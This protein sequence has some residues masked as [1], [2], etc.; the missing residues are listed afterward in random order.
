MEQVKSTLKAKWLKNILR[1]VGI[2]IL[3]VLITLF[4]GYVAITFF[5]NINIQQWFQHT[6]LFWLGVRCMLYAIISGLVCGIY[7]H[8]AIS[9]KTIGFLVL[10]I[11]CCEILNILYIIN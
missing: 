7:R 11:V 1:F 3:V 6:K 2:L 4:F 9:G 8:Q 5:P 10:G